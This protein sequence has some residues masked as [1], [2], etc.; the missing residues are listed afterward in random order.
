LINRARRVA[1]LVCG[2]SK[3]PALDVVW[4]GPRDPAL[5][6]A[7]SIN[8]TAGELWWFLDMRALPARDRVPLGELGT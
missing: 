8:P 3:S 1:F 6:P 4:H 5:Y 7:Q 2:E